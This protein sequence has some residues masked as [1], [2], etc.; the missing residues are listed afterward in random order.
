MCC[1]CPLSLSLSLLSLPSLVVC[2]QI[3]S[4]IF[5]MARYSVCCLAILGL[6]LL[7]TGV[8]AGYDDD[9]WREPLRGPFNGRQMKSA[10]ELQGLNADGTFNHENEPEQ[11]NHAIRNG[12]LDGSAGW[13]PT[14]RTGVR[15]KHS[16][17]RS[18]GAEFGG[19]PDMSPELRK[20]QRSRHPEKEFADGDFDG[21]PVG[22]SSMGSKAPTPNKCVTASMRV[23]GNRVMQEN[24]AMF[25]LCVYEQREKLGGQD[26]VEWA[27]HPEPCLQDME[28]SCQKMNPPST[29][30]CLM[31]KQGQLSDY[32]RNSPFFQSLVQGFENFNKKA[33]ADP[34]F[35]SGA[36]RG[37][38]DRFAD[39]A[40]REG[41]PR[42]DGRMTDSLQLPKSGPK[43][44]LPDNADVVPDKPEYHPMMDL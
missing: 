10:E 6:A 18:G 17:S 3:Y 9:N 21:I 33:S 27:S 24:F 8:T 14:K 4:L 13:N 23:C 38:E 25:S 15:K 28:K 35:M 41:R 19:I 43:T 31:K 39:G 44:D 5:L 42:R 34:N 36:R 26:C 7:A 29:T 11:P 37:D 2:D 20:Q 1:R 22:T 40:R 16:R 32:C 12:N 30:S